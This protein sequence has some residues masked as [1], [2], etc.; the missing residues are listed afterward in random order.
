[1]KNRKMVL[2]ASALLVC[3][4]L[5]FGMMNVNA[6]WTVGVK[7]G[8]WADYSVV[9]TNSDGTVNTYTLKL[10][11]TKIE[12]TTVYYN[13]SWN[14]PFFTGYSGS[15]DISSGDNTAA[16]SGESAFFAFPFFIGANRN[17]GDILYSGEVVFPFLSRGSRYHDIIIYETIYREYSGQ[18]IEVN[19]VYVNFN[20]TTYYSFYWIRA[21]GMLAELES[22]QEEVLL[23][24]ASVIPEFPTPLLLLAL[25]STT[26]P[27]IIIVRHRRKQT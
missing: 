20:S 10:D 27:A 5:F 11:V 1:M 7:V 3:A 13:L 2:M 9:L 15:M 6:T 12:S 22:P 8:D 26:I 21:T 16:H 24:S 17:A 25:V 18:N 14:P 23:T 4:V 19:H